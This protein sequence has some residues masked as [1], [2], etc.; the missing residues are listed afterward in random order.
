MS[1]KVTYVR[2]TWAGGEHRFQIDLS[3]ELSLYRIPDPFARLQRLLLGQWSAEDV[4]GTIRRGLGRADTED[5]FEQHCRR[6][7][8][9]EL[10]P[11]AQTILGVAIF[12]IDKA[13]ADQGLEPEQ[14]KVHEGDG[15]E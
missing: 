14:V 9:S 10:V 8:I 5:L 1:E 15:D 12:G 11:L 3:S 13:I 2:L 6:R 7:P 4:Y